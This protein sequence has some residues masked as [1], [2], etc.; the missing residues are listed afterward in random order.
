MTD[1][2][3]NP[4]YSDLRL[5][6]YDQLNALLPM[7]NTF[8]GDRDPRFRTWTDMNHD[9]LVERWKTDPGYTT[10]VSF[11][12]NVDRKI[13]ELPYTG[14][15]WFHSFGFDIC[16]A[17]GKGW[18][19]WEKDGPRPAR[20]DFFLA[21]NAKGE[22]QHVGVFIEVFGGRCSMIAGGG[23]D[24]DCQKITRTGSSLPPAFLKGWLNIDE[25]YA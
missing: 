6:L 18:H 13:K 22:N 16:G 11:M 17:N 15:P 7:D 9:M 19:V 1:Y 21:M 8:I 12:T 14:M 5:W 24:K 23:G 3:D 20:G 2:D 25:F 10:C 4:Y